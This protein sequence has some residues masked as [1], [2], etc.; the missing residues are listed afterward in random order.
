MTRAKWMFRW[1][2]LL[3]L[4]V[5]IVACEDYDLEVQ[6]KTDEVVEIYIDEFYEGAAASI[7]LFPVNDPIQSIVLHANGANVD[8]VLL[9][10]RPVKRA[11]RLLHGDLARA[12]QQLADS[13][14][15]L[16]A[17]ASEG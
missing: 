11:G 12:K 7:G 17:A 3:M 14:A 2:L 6:N 13:G 4:V 15:R 9:N 8:T 1:L 16:L 10:G 5:G